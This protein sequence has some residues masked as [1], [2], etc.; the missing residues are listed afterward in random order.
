MSPSLK[1][2]FFALDVKAPWPEVLPIGRIIEEQYR[3]L[4][5]AFLGGL[6]SHGLIEQL[7]TLPPPGFKV[8]I[9]GKFEQ[10]LF[11][12]PR[13]AHVVAWK[14]EWL[15][16]AQ[17][18]LQFQND[19]LDWLEKNNLPA[20]RRH[21]FLPH[22]TVARSPFNIKPWRKSFETLPLFVSSLHLFE[23]LGNSKYVS[24]WQWPI[25]PPF[26][27][28]DHTA[29]L[30]FRVYGMNLQE[31][32]VHAQIALCFSFPPL[33]NFLNNEQIALTSVE[34]VI[35][36]LNKVVCLADQKIGCPFKAVS[37]HGKATEDENQILQWEMIIDV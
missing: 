10:P 11:L 37:Y 13:R 2:L 14:I 4:T 17:L 16:S 9:V 6:E 5:L 36:H 34:E 20:D 19:L 1:R 27:E 29:D 23:S 3:H 35:T 22:V 31:L 12:P 15:Q 8:G 24:L 30:A 32:F 18:L 25:Q 21:D 33:L 26:E 7:K 28:M